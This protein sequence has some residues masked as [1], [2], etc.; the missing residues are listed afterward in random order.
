MRK[1]TEFQKIQA[2]ANRRAWWKRNKQ[3]I[4]EFCGLLAFGA[5]GWWFWCLLCFVFPDW[6]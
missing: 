3:D 5:F 2:R 1:Y 6:P 4:L